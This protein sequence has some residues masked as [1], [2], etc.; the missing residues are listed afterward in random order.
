MLMCELQA[1][2]ALARAPEPDQG[3]DLLVLA[4]VK[5][6]PNLCK[7]LGTAGKMLG[8]CARG[9][10]RYQCSVRAYQVLANL[11]RLPA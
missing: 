10:W 3:K 4:T 8:D 2:F 7:N 6:L 1:Y 5:C 9:F 11:P